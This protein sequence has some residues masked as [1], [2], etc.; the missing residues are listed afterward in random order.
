MPT[1]M[2]TRRLLKYPGLW[3]A[4]KGSFGVV[5]EPL[6]TGTLR[7]LRGGFFHGLRFFDS[8][9]TEQVVESAAPKRLPRIIDRLLNR[10]IEIELR[11]GSSS[12]ASVGEVAERLCS[13][14]AYQHG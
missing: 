12:D 5:D 1:L 6:A 3:I 7:A 10:Q 13:C 2:C 4:R 9:G 8:R 11:L 14:G